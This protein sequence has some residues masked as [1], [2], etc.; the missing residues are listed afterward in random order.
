M[1]HM[2]A[3]PEQ[4]WFCVLL[5]ALGLEVFTRGSIAATEPCVLIEHNRV[6]TR[7]AAAE[8]RQ[9]G[10][11]TTLATAHGICP[12]VT[13]YAKDHDRERQRLRLLAEMVYRFSA[14][15]S[16]HEPDC[17][18]L[19]AGGSLKL[20]G[21]IY[22][23]KRN[24]IRLLSEMGHQAEIGIAPTP[25]VAIAFARAGY[26][27]ELAP[28][29]SS[30]ALRTYTATGLARMSLGHTELETS[31]VERLGNM[32]LET[33]GQLLRLPMAELGRRFGPSL[34]DYLARLRGAKPDPRRIVTPVA[35][36]SERVE[37]LEAVTDKQG[38]LFPMQRLLGELES[39]LTARQLG[40]SRLHWR[41]AP[42]Q[43]SAVALDVE[44]STLQQHRQILLAISRLKLEQTPLPAEIVFLELASSEAESWRPTSDTLFMQGQRPRHAPDQLI[45]RFRARLGDRAC[46]GLRLYEDH[47]PEHAWQP[48]AVRMPMHKKRGEDIQTPPRPI[49]L[50][51]SPAPVDRSQIELLSG[52][53]RID[54]GWWD[55][56]GTTER[57]GSAPRRSVRRDYYVAHHWNGAYCWVF[58]SLVNGNWFLH[59]YFS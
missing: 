2:S 10:L 18:L 21:G 12:E 3:A 13:H 42:L 41:F 30:A 9:I 8:H 50:L 32:G 22:R 37:L 28:Y 35:S 19:E 44:F 34:L 27:G 39:W 33:L 36:F 23:L 56:Q 6:V 55:V 20:F 38:L 25:L 51:E 16:I 1:L 15:V 58:Q 47:R 59:G 52:P 7:N 54:T 4:L 49:W 11:G 5:P 14:R 29:P 57:I 17:L 53:E 43:G 45:D 48:T 46:H 40:T 24:L 26:K 31:L